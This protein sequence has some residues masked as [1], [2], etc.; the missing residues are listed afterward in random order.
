MSPKFSTS[1]PDQP[2]PVI[3]L[4]KC[5]AKRSD[6][7]SDRMTVEDHLRLVGLIAEE[8]LRR[9]PE[10]VKRY[11]PPGI[12]SLTSLHDVGKVSPGFQKHIWGD[13]L[14]EV[15][16][17]L[18][19]QGGFEEKHA[20]IGESTVRAYYAQFCPEAANWSMIVGMHHSDYRSCRQHQADVYGG[21]QWA[22][23]R[24]QIVDKVV[25][26]FGQLPL[27]EPQGPF[28]TATGFVCLA[29]WLASDEGLFTQSSPLPENDELHHIINEKLDQIG[30]IWPE[31]TRGLSFSDL[32][33][34]AVTQ[35]FGP[36]EVQ[37]A[38]YRLANKPGLLVIEAPMGLGKTEAALWAAYRLMSEGY[39]HG[40]YFAL[41][42]RL[43]SNLLHHRVSAFLHRAFGE[44]VA[45]RLLH[46]YAW[47]YRA[48]ESE[49]AGGQEL[50][51]GG[52]WFEP[53]KRA[54]LWPFGVGTV[55]QALLGVLAVRHYF[56]RLFALAGKVVVLD[57][58]HSYDLYTGTL[59]DRLIELL[60]QLGSSVIVLS[61][62]LTAARRERLGCLVPEEN[63]EAYPLLS[64][65]DGKVLAV[66]VT[67][68]AHKTV[69]ICR[70]DESR[71][72]FW[73][74]LEHRL[75]QGQVIVWVCNT[76]DKAQRTFRQACSELPSQLAELGLLH[77]HMLPW[78][79][80]EKEE[81]WMSMLG[82]KSLK[83]GPCLL[84]A[85][86]V[87]EQSVDLDADLLISE[88]APIDMLLQR[89][90][91]LWRHERT[92][93]PAE[94][95]ECWLLDWHAEVADSA[96]EFRQKTGA[97]GRVYAPYVLWRTLRTLG[98]QMVRAINIPEDIRNLLEETYI[99]PQS[100]DP[101]WINDLYTELRARETKMQQLAI[102]MQSQCL[103]QLKDTEEVATRFNSEK[104]A[105]VLVVRRYT[106]SGDLVELELADGKRVTLFPR[107]IDRR[108]AAQ[109]HCNV[110]QVPFRLL[111]NTPTDQP[112][113]LR[114][115]VSPNAK[116]LLW[117]KDGILYNLDKTDSGLRYSEQLGLFH[118]A[119][120]MNLTKGIA[121]D[122]FQFQFD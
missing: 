12:V 36:N 37:Q 43:T 114:A 67:E 95:A 106:L 50:A 10:P 24:E 47:L 4:S 58:V 41:P 98:K 16:P 80:K 52:S 122:D 25:K 2:V 44:E 14:E 103:P 116:V 83:R 8:L 118:E 90:G 86:Q 1:K 115:V 94:R 105:P 78:H 28:Q 87:V 46:G 107:R 32:F 91:R 97:S 35:P 55:D 66:S 6:D 9:L 60:L 56:L 112:K 51:P 62:T 33:R 109:V 31:I 111:D 69:W 19:P 49:L 26:W 108:A 54:L 96:K 64:R 30:F 120:V 88:L 89:I 102:A 72:Q 15:S 82:K 92:G 39:N 73:Q 29:D 104:H 100:D 101:P 40:L 119:S 110:M 27:T 53:S 45:T 21:E 22:R 113:W 59:I 63:R 99:E 76:V 38:A 23:I 61:A 79:R 84:V 18:S 75:Q 13:R 20:E 5:L 7:D 68:T 11:L 93:R 117:D 48:L 74:E 34:S 121:D 71:Q 3:P 17:A 70:R 57:E 42:T 65:G 85:T 81:K 77:S